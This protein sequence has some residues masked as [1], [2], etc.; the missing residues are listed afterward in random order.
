MMQVFSG[1]FLCF[2]TAL[3]TAISCHGQ[4]ENKRNTGFYDLVNIA[5]NDSLSVRAGAGTSHDVIA[6]IPAGTKFISSNGKQQTVG[7][8]T[9]LNVHYG[10]RE[11]WVNKRYLQASQLQCLGTEPFWSVEL[12]QGVISFRDLDEVTT[13]F[14]L[15]SAT[16]SA[17]HTNQWMLTTQSSSSSKLTAALLETKQCSDSMSDR[18]YQYNILLIHSGNQVYSGCCNAL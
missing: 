15:T 12:K 14:A 5:S 2:L 7:K 17:N 11:G 3:L 18:N 9:W 4:T 10:Q 16:L 8:S 1:K 6:K 13:T